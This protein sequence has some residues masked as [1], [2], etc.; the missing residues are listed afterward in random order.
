MNVTWK[1]RAKT[2]ALVTA[3]EAVALALLLVWG[4]REL[5]RTAGYED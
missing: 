3:A 4:Y 5:N 2:F 1:R